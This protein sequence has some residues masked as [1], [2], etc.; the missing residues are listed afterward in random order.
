[1]SDQCI[2]R[3]TTLLKSFIDAM[4][5]NIPQAF[6]VVGKWANQA[7]A[8]ARLLVHSARFVIGPLTHNLKCEVYSLILRCKRK[9]LLYA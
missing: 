9:E 1:M 7:R 4:Q 2:Q 6:Q 8:H 3:Q 5:F